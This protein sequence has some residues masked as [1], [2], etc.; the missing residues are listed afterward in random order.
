MERGHLTDGYT[1]GLHGAS[2][3]TP[4]APHC[5]LHTGPARGLTCYPGCTSL[6]ATHRACMGPHLSPRVHL[7]AGY[8]QGLHGSSLV[9][10]GASHCWL[11]TGSAR[12]LSGYPGDISLLATH[13]AC[14]GPHLLPWVPLTAG[15]TRGLLPQVVE[16][17]IE[18]KR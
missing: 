18:V 15:Y 10:P 4:G 16:L 12:V 3:V 9:T 5:W 8:T 14:T 11:H 1:Q 13:R 2:P 17:I 7:T 6:M